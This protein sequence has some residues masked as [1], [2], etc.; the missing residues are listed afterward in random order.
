MNNAC[1]INQDVTGGTPGSY[2]SLIMEEVSISQVHKASILSDFFGIKKQKYDLADVWVPNAM[3]NDRQGMGDPSL[4]FFKIMWLFFHFKFRVKLSETQ[5]DPMSDFR[6]TCRAG[7]A[8][9]HTTLTHHCYPKAGAHIKIHFSCGDV[10][11]FWGTYSIFGSLYYHT[12]KFQGLPDFEPTHSPLPSISEVC[13]VW[14]LYK[15][16]LSFH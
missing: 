3:V 9:T 1:S 2:G 14:N 12:G 11:G 5:T 7:L 13:Y 8:T 6:H 10:Y 15:I 4:S 16:E